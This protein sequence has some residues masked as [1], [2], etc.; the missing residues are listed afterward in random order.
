MC[1]FYV[2]RLLNLETQKNLIEFCNIFFLSKLGK[3]ATLSLKFASVLSAAVPVLFNLLSLFP[4]KT[5]AFYSYIIVSFMSSRDF[6][7][8][9]FIC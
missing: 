3:S 4:V 6:V 7:G 8:M 1:L 5:T 2:E 9:C